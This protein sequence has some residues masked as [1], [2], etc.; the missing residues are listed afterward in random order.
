MTISARGVCGCGHPLEAHGHVAG[1]DLSDGRRL[2]DVWVCE[3]GRLVAD[4][5]TASPWDFVCGCL[6]HIDPAGVRP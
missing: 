6:L 1:V 4:P 3:G 2:P 5:E